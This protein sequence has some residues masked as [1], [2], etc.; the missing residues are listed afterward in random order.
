MRKSAIVIALVNLALSATNA[1]STEIAQADNQI[2]T[3]PTSLWRGFYSGLNV[4]YGWSSPNTLYGAETRLP[5]LT[6]GLTGANW[7]TQSPLAQGFFGGAQLGY[8]YQI[9]NTGVVLGGEVDFQGAGLSGASEGLGSYDARHRYFPFYKTSQSL[10]WFG[11]VRGRLGYAV[12]PQLLIYGT[13]GFAYGGGVN[14][15]GIIYSDQKEYAGATKSSTGTGWTAGGGVEWALWNNWSIKTE[16]L[17]LSLAN[18]PNL[19]AQQHCTCSVLPDYFLASQTSASNHYH[20]LRVG[21][22]YHFDLMSL[23]KIS[24]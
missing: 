10:D 16:Y 2:A 24:R 21:I 5:P 20:T 15:L 13:G 11:T 7:I 18:F 14:D 6:Y 22:N 23:A 9:N 8:N 17:Y 1:F 4:G 3:S 12:A 19:A